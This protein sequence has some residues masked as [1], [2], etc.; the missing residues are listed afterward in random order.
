MTHYDR[1]MSLAEMPLLN[2]NF[3]HFRDTST[4]TS[5]N[6]IGVMHSLVALG[7]SGAATV[8]SQAFTTG[9]TAV[10]G[11]PTN[12]LRWNH[13]TAATAGTPELLS[14]IEDVRT[15][16]GKKVM[17]QGYYRANQAFDIKLKQDFGAGG[18]PSADVTVAADGNSSTLP[19][20]TDSAGVVQWRPFSMVYTL[21]TLAGKTIGSTANTSY[22]GIRYLWPLNVLFQVDLADIRI[23]AGGERI[24]VERRRPV[25]EEGSLLD[26]YYVSTT[27]F[28]PVSTQSSNWVPFRRVMTKVPTMAGG[29]GS[30]LGTATVDGFPIISSGAAAAITAITADARIAD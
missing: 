8:S 7:T 9:Q 1:S 30:T 4:I 21:P 13:T 20:T 15:F 18:S 23:H 2:G 17:V 28:A 14:K 29:T 27:A 16:A 5:A 11:E 12:F 10:P 19:I 3:D 6:F 24:P 22:L 26:R 25:H